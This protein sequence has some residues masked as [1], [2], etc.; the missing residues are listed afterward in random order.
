MSVFRVGLLLVLFSS[1][2]AGQEELFAKYAS[3]EASEAAR[4]LAIRSIQEADCGAGPGT[5]APATEAELADPPLHSGF[6]MAAMQTGLVSAMLDWCDLDWEARSFL[7]LM[8]YH[9]TA[10][11]LGDRE[12]AMMGLVHE[13][14]RTR[15]LNGLGAQPCPD[16]TRRNLHESVPGP[17]RDTDV[18]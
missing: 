14:Q 6:A 3:P 18:K 16:V 8:N 12:M 4:Q 15:I 9:R 17:D 2:A 7:P 1:P 10:A 5:C 11:N 13:I